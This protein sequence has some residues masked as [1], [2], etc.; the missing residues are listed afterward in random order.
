MFKYIQEGVG[1]RG[2]SVLATKIII[3]SIK[4]LKMILPSSAKPSKASAST[5]AEFSLNLKLLLPPPSDKV[6]IQLK[7]NTASTLT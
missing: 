3:D 7:V 1:A 6:V 5:S 2:V 4:V